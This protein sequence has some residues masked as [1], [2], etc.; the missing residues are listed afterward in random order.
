[1][2]EA[3]NRRTNIYLSKPS[4]TSSSHNLFAFKLLTPMYAQDSTKSSLAP[5]NRDLVT[6]TYNDLLTCSSNFL[7]LSFANLDHITLI[8]LSNVKVMWL[9]H[10]IA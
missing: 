4:S 3:L 2:M 6:D 10:M 8:S 7:K 9:L 1:M 5:T